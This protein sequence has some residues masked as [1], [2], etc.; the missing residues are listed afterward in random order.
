LMVDCWEELAGWADY[1]VVTQRPDAD[2]ADRLRASGLP[3]LDLVAANPALEPLG[4]LTG[5]PGP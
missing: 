5:R 1:L 2:H 3:V 4:V